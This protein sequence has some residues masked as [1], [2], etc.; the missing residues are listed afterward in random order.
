MR[1]KKKAPSLIKR[2]Y[3][4]YR[5]QATRAG[6]DLPYTVTDLRQLI[7]AHLHTEECPYCLAPLTLANFCVDH[8]K[9]ISRGGSNMLN[10][11]IVCCTRCNQAKGKLTGYE[12]YALL[13]IMRE[14]FS[15][16]ARKDVVRR[17]IAGGRYR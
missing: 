7:Q 12:Y 16:E 17:L 3:N 9:P 13:R 6:H 4:I 8:A 1:K 2:S 15:E 14:F 10:N 11:L 5:H